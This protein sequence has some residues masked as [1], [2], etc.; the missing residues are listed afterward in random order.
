MKV[1]I[2]NG[3]PRGENSNSSRIISWISKGLSEPAPQNIIRNIDQH[4]EYIDSLAEYDTILIVFPLYIDAMPGIV[5]KF[6]ETLYEKKD[7]IKGK[8]IYFLVHSGFP[9]AAH[10]LLTKEYLESLS[11]KLELNYKDT[12]IY[13]G[14][15]GTRFSDETKI[16]KKVALFE[17]V[18]QSIGKNNIVSHYIKSKLEKPI[19]FTKPVVVIY[20]VLS[21]IV[22]LNFYWD[23]A[24]K[25]NNAYGNR[26]DRPYLS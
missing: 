5:M 16:T 19:R 18:G 1:C 25:K 13:G 14:S 11:Q 17:S 8:N 21:K 15:E 26:F 20:K 24:L 6:F 10:S 9:E 4:K 12:I 22:N 2:F 23:N 7:M 3:S